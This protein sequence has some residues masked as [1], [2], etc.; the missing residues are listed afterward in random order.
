[1]TELETMQRAKMYMDQL[2]QGMDPISGGSLPVGSG[3][4]QQRLSRC[5]AYVSGVLQKVIENGGVVGNRE[6]TVEFALTPQQRQSVLIY[7]QPV[8]I[9]DWIETL[10]RAAGN[11]DMKRLNAGKITE[12]LVMGGF[13]VKQVDQEG[14]I[15][16]VPTE[17][18]AALGLTVQ[19]RQGRDGLYFTVYYS[20]AAQRYLMDNLDNILMWKKD[21]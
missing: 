1:M 15:H 19:Q 10:Y 13:L 7:D 6:K 12:W 4:D 14:R 18:G 16:R 17:R 20:A 9:S 2:A 3:L 5:F 8:R 21:G 11:P